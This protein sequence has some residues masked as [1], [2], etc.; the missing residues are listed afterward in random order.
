MSKRRKAFMRN[1][2]VSD[3]KFITLE[4]EVLESLA[5]QDLKSH[6]KVLLQEFLIIHRP[7]SQWLP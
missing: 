3:Y 6:A 1:K 7:D 4:A 5:Y 2:T